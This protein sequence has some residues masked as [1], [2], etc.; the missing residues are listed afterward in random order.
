MVDRVVVDIYGYLSWIVASLLLLSALLFLESRP[1]EAPAWDPGVVPAKRYFSL[2]TSQ[3]LVGGR[4][5]IF[6]YLAGAFVPG[7]SNIWPVKKGRLVVQLA[8]SQG[9]PQRLKDLSRCDIVAET[10]GRRVAM[11]NELRATELARMIDISAVQTCHDLTDVAE[12]ARVARSYGF[13]A[14]HVLPG[15]VPLL[16]E[17]L[18]G[19]DTL[20]G[21]RVGFPSG[22]STTRIK[23]AEVRDLVEI[24]ISGGAEFVK[25]STGWTPSGAT[26]DHVGFITQFDRYETVCDRV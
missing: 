3:N 4:C 14:A 5:A 10:G 25:S 11:A 6:G 24:C 16:K 17:Q 18:T 9:Q 12:L 13:I 23:L 7:R 1:N 2:P 21:A 20:V 26:L 19:S 22:G 15:F 8:N